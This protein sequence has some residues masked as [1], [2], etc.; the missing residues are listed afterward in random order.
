MIPVHV[1]ECNRR[2]VQR[3][4]NDLKI[5]SQDREQRLRDDGDV[6]DSELE[7]VAREIVKAQRNRKRTVKLQKYETVELFTE[8]LSRKMKR[9]LPKRKM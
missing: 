5:C 9:L 6:T 4:G 1:W 8:N 3:K 2:N 7:K